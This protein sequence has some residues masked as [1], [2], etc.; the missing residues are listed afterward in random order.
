[1]RANVSELS[2]H[3]KFHYRETEVLHLWVVEEPQPEIASNI[4]INVGF[5]SSEEIHTPLNADALLIK[6]DIK[7]H[8]AIFKKI[9][10]TCE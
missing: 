2:A 4:Q 10:R 1:M 6:D 7:L 8:K 3:I 5:L 9:P